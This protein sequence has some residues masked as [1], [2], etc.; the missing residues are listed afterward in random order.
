MEWIVIGLF[1]I[2]IVCVLV[3]V[4]KKRTDEIEEYFETE[5]RAGGSRGRDNVKADEEKTVD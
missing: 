1:V 5:K 2:A 4:T 3:R